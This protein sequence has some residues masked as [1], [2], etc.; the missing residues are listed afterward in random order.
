MIK[1]KRT[2]SVY[3]IIAGLRIIIITIAPEPGLCCTVTDICI[4]VCVIQPKRNVDALNLADMILW[5]KCFR[6]KP[7]TGKMLFQ[8]LL[9]RFLV[10]L[11]RDHIIRLQCTGQL[12]GHYHRTSAK[13]AGRCCRIGISHDLTAT[14]LAHIGTQPLTLP[15]LPLTAGLIRPAHILRLL[16]LHSLDIFR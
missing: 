9:C 4:C 16:F 15:V 1:T 10:Q 3:C 14:G 12:P 2:T 8:P 13:R 5:L 7:L 11:K 6:Q